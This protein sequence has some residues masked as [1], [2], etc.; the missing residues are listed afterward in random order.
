MPLGAL[1]TGMHLQPI[2][3]RYK[4]SYGH[5]HERRVPLHH[6]PNYCV[7]RLP[8]ADGFTGHYVFPQLY[9]PSAVPVAEKEG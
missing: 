3:V 8:G 6:I 1:T 2:V 4:D 5:H 9:Q 7:L